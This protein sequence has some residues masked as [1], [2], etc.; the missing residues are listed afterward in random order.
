MQEKQQTGRKPA[1]FRPWVL[2]PMALAAILLGVVIWLV[3]FLSQR[4]APKPGPAVSGLSVEQYLADYWDWYELK[5][6]DA[7]TGT[8]ELTAPINSKIDV[9]LA[10]AQ[11]YALLDGVRYDELALSDAENL[12]KMLAGQNGEGAVGEA[13]GIEVRTIV[14]SRLSCEGETVY[15]VDQNGVRWQCWAEP[16]DP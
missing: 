10:Q 1:R 8:L 3:I 6:W 9:T 4:V 11:K 5:S 14:L 7:E 12:R 13:C 16:Q 2:I 15:T